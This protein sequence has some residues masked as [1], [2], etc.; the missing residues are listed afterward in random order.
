MDNKRNRQGVPASKTPRC[1]IS[2]IYT[3]TMEMDWLLHR[4]RTRQT[5]VPY[6]PITLV[7]G[8]F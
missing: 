7:L 3:T 1:T 6:T 2:A 4:R 8:T 5:H